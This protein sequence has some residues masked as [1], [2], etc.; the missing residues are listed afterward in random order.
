MQTPPLLAG[1]LLL[2]HTHAYTDSLRH[3]PAHVRARVREHAQLPERLPACGMPQNGT[4]SE[5]R[6]RVLVGKTKALISVAALVETWTRVFT[7]VSLL[8]RVHTGAGAVA[9][10]GASSRPGWG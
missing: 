4:R 9:G 8:S 6:A 10:A 5:K 7:V 2:T 1:Q 3:E